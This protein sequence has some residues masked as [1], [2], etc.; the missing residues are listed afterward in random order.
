[1]RRG[2]DLDGGDLLGVA[3]DSEEALHLQGVVGQGATIRCRSRACRKNVWQGIQNQYPWTGGRV[4]F[5][6]FPQQHS[7][8]Y[9]W[10]F[11]KKYAWRALKL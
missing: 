2:G 4:K 9:A 7:M 3:G 11:R 10:T 8:S 6:N 5:R 1:M